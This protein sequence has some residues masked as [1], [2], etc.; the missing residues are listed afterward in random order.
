MDWKDILADK[1]NEMG[2]VG[3]D[4]DSAAPPRSEAPR[5]RGVLHIDIERKG[6]AGKTATIISGFTIDDSEVKK[7]A[8]QLQRA[9]GCGGSSRSGEILLQGERREAVASQL[10]KL[11][12]KTNC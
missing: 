11:G 4:S 2:G 7:L 6:R 10:R 5:Q 3:D 12:Y 1:L 8:S 9:L